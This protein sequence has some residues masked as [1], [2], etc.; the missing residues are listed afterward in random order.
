[1]DLFKNNAA[2][3]VSTG[4]NASA[5]SIALE[6]GGGLRF[7]TPPFNAIWWNYTDFPDPD[8][9]ANREIVRV[10]GISTD[11]LT[12]TRAQES[13]SATVKNLAGKTYRMMAPLTAKT[14]NTDIPSLATAAAAALLPIDLSDA[15][16]ATG[17]LAAGRM[18]ALTGD[19]TNT[20][21]SLA[22]TIANNAVT[23]AKIAN[24]NVTKAKIENVTASRLLGRGASGA[25][26]PEEITL[27]TNLSITGTTLNAAG[28]GGGLSDGDYG[29]ITVSGSSTVLTI[30]NG[31]VSL[32]KMADMATDSII[33][34]ATA[35]TGAP[36]VLTALPFAF[37]GDVTRAAD[38]NAQT[39]ANDAVTTV[40]ILNSNVTLAKLA[41]IATDS[42]LGRATAS[43]GVVEVLAALPFAFT[44]DVTRAADSNAQTIAN[45]AVTTAKILDS[46]VTLA[47]IANI[48]NNTILG[49]AS[50]GA[51][52]PSAL[53]VVPT[54]AFPALTGDVT[55]A[56]GS[57]ATTIANDAVT[58]AKIL[59]SNVTLAKIASIAT[60]SIL[61]RASASTGVIEVITALPWAFSGDVTSV[62]D[63]NALTIANDAVT[64][65]KMQNV[66]AAS[67]LLGR[68]DSG[69]GDVEEITIG[70]GL[71]MTGSTLSASGGGGS[72]AGSD[73]QVQFNDGGAFGADAGFVYAK[74]T[75]IVSILGSPG[76]NTAPVFGIEVRNPNAATVGNQQ[77]SGGV[78]WEAQGWK[79][80]A[81]A[82]SQP[83]RF[84]A[85]VN[86]IQDAASPDGSWILASSVNGGAFSNPLTYEKDGTLT[87]GEY[88]L[89]GSRA[90]TWS[91]RGQ[92]Y[93]D[94]SAEFAMYNSGGSVIASCLTAV[95]N[96]TKTS[97]YTVA[98]L[99]VGT[100]FNNIGA[101]G[102]VI[103]TLPT[104][105]AKQHY[106]FAVH[107]TQT[108][109]ISAVGSD[110][111]RYGA[112]VSAAA[113]NISA[114]AK[115]C[116]LHLFCPVAGEWFIDQL[117]GT[118]AGPT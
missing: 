35:G 73:T 58:T 52:A 46:N 10:T 81:T 64:Y 53:T 90:I 95:K 89:T 4:Y 31:V 117:T 41:D 111:I 57:L 87:S 70:S 14:L 24:A 76:A 44:G 50:G 109:Q 3:Y 101:G 49:N 98:A 12:V 2:A 27:G 23:T 37:T 83:L 22:T 74:T 113:G 38:S 48:A 80:N 19:V 71:T 36:E 17:T 92:L 93:A 78:Y 106:F 28:G 115:G 55:N 91:G 45:D 56:A 9:D 67:K 97:D 15:G 61:G 63:A 60:D 116:T 29:D 54:A 16:E 107:A 21:G 66:S 30:D 114:N 20:A 34:R 68:G 86:T 102:T 65:A 59:N 88:I 99:D 25:G 8:F 105:V 72:V 79:T 1:M 7:P 94:A 69:A 42:I 33:G 43:T 104:S 112:T 6:G 96:L 32:A 26:A 82:A 47:K 108:V 11:T 103:F 100:Y 18:P 13:T 118:W 5:T 84:R 39:I 85:Y 51:A 75:D 62:A 77:F 40:K 110:T